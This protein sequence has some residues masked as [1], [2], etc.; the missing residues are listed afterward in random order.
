MAMIKSASFSKYEN[1]NIGILNVF[2]DKIRV[3]S[4]CV[5]IWNVPSELVASTF[6]V[7]V[8][9]RRA[10]KKNGSL[11][12]ISFEKAFRPSKYL[13]AHH[14]YLLL[15]S[16]IPSKTLPGFQDFQSCF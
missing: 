16:S 3:S 7:T 11:V 4:G 6:Y 9:I 10:I 14:M 1:E 15:A 5:S 2:I 8:K 13:I 12:A